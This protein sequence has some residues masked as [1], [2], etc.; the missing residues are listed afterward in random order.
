MPES[1]SVPWCSPKA[2]AGEATLNDE[3][4]QAKLEALGATLV[5]SMG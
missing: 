5:T 3:A 1:V 2:F 4:V